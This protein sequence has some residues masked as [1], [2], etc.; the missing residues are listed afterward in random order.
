[1]SYQKTKEYDRLSFLYLLAGNTEKLQKMHKI[2]ELRGDVMS[3]FHTAMFLGDADERVKVLEATGQLTLAYI[4]AVTHSLPEHKERLAELLEGAGLAIPEVAAGAPLLQP[5]TP[6]IR[7][8]NWPLLAVSKNAVDV[9]QTPASDRPAQFDDEEDLGAEVGGAWG[10]DDEDLF[11]D[12]EDEKKAGKGKDVALTGEAGAWADDD[13]LDL[14]DDED[15]R[16]AA[17]EGKGAGD[18]F[19]SVPTGGTP[20]VV[21]WCAES[22]HAADHFAA[23]SAESGLQLLHRQIALTQAAALKAAATSLALGAC[24][25]LPGPPLAPPTRSYLARDDGKNTNGKPMPSVPI[26]VDP[27]LQKLKNVYR[28]FTAGQFADCEGLLKE[29]LS[30]IPLVVANSRTETNDIKELLS[31]CREY[32][33]AVRVK[34]AIGGA[35]ADPVRSL[36]LNAY[37]THCNLQPSHLMLALKTAMFAAFK[38][39]NFINATSFARR[40]LELPDMGSE[41]NADSRIKAQKVLTKGE[42]A[43]RNEHKIDYDEMNPF[44]LDCASFKPLYKG[45][46]LVK[47]S[48]CASTYAP[49]QQGQV[50]VT[51][52]LCA[53][54]VETIGLVASASSGSGRR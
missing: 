7:G 31:V 28:C 48:Y 15:E 3:R 46:A 19:F 4:A 37:F 43:G 29:I 32:M 2:A 45:A 51:C 6:I 38:A 13:D 27:L 34:A 30:S 25:F 35:T 9:S 42:Q 39:K 22:T 53:V 41:R 49:E 50:C 20:A 47:C 40:L 18:S 11:G 33:T 16:P 8:D 23:A 44:S 5:P 54:G 10:G 36:E 14:S 21:S 24:G 52:N 12:E 17:K 1:M 26:K